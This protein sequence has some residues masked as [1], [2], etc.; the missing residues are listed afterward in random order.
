MLSGVCSGGQAL[1]GKTSK[2]EFEKVT[3]TSGA[4]RAHVLVSASV[5]PLYICCYI[6][7]TLIAVRIEQGLFYAQPRRVEQCDLDSKQYA[8]L[9]KGIRVTAVS[10]AKARAR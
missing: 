10:M 3:I 8:S 4:S 9:H 7:Y 2:G 5:F 1:W 6:T